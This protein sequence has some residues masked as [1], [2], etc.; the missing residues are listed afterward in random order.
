MCPSWVASDEASAPPGPPIKSF[1]SLPVAIYESDP[2]EPRG[3]ESWS[4]SSLKTIRR[5]S[6]RKRRSSVMVIRSRSLAEPLPDASYPVGV[7]L[8]VG[9]DDGNTLDDRL[10]DEKTVEGVAVVAGQCGLHVG[11]LDG[12]RQDRQ[13]KVGDGLVHPLAVRLGQVELLQPDLDRHFPQGP[14]PEQEFVAQVP[15][16]GRRPRAEWVGS[17]TAQIRV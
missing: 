8:C 17:S 13:A 5:P 12:D 16:F 11:V 1:L 6:S 14:G 3:V 4:G 15:K 2:A 7:E 9:A 10:C